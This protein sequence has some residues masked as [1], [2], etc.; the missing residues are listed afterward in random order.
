MILGVL[1]KVFAALLILIGASLNS[2]SCGRQ[3]I[4]RSAGGP[5]LNFLCTTQELSP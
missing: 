3:G 1:M 4:L 2:E 5:D